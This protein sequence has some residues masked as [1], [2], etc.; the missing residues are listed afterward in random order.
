MKKTINHVKP[1]Y[2]KVSA[3]LRLYINSET[4]LVLI[5]DQAKGCQ[6]K[7]DLKYNNLNKAS[8]KM[9]YDTAAYDCRYRRVDEYAQFSRNIHN[10]NT[11]LCNSFQPVKTP[12]KI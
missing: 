5:S 1:Q 4:P 2:A 3:Q 7:K 6:H 9:V 10:K 11:P 12:L 8:K